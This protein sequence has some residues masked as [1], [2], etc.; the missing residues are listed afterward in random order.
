[1]C[2]KLFQTRYEVKPKK[3]HS[4]KSD[5]RRRGT[6]YR[7]REAT[8]REKEMGRALFHYFIPPPPDDE[9]AEKGGPSESTLGECFPTGWWWTPLH[10]PNLPKLQSG[11][12]I[13]EHRAR[14]SSRTELC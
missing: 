13:G 1:M 5:M 6:G 10:Q 14:S 4:N 2:V 8:L 11:W 12:I 7:A 9:S 3:K